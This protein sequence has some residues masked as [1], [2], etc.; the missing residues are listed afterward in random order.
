MKKIDVTKTQMEYYTEEAFKSLRTNLQFCGED[1]KVI[2]VTSCTENE[3]KTQIALNLSISLAEANKKV[4]LIDADLRKS[5]MIGRVKAP[6]TIGGLSHFL[7][8]QEKLIEVLYTTNIPCFNMI[9]AGPVPPNPSELLNGNYFEQMIK[10]LRDTCDYVIIDA[11]PLGS[12]ID[13]A[14]IARCCDGSLLVIESGWNSWRFEAEVKEQLE[15]T[16]CPILGVVLNKYDVKAEK[17]YGR[18]GKYGKYGKY[19]GKT[20][21]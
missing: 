1:K 17:Y 10:Q 11:P 7:S 2:V 8:K 3:G 18:Y 4:V 6:E 5:V 16:G 19:G 15:K 21:K 13:A 9:F 20:E 14:I 12:V